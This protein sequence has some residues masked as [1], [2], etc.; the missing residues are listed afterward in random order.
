MFIVNVVSMH[1][2]ATYADLSK[3][4]VPTSPGLMNWAIV[5]YL[6]N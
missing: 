3:D 6:G 1:L 2:S 5:G 4:H